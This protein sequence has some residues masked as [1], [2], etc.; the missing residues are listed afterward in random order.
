MPWFLDPRPPLIDHGF[1]E[2]SFFTFHHPDYGVG[3]STD[4]G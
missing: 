2:V 4:G 3:L 1:V